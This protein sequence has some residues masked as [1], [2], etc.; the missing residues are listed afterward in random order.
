MLPK[1]FTKD[2]VRR[3]LKHF[4]N[5]HWGDYVYFLFHTGARPSEAIGLRWGDV[6]LKAGTARI[7]ST[8]R[9]SRGS[10]SKRERS[11]TKTGESRLIPLSTVLVSRLYLK[12]GEEHELIFTSPKGHPIDDRNFRRRYWKPALTKLGIEYRRPY[13]MRS[14]CESHLLAS[15]MSV[16]DV[17]AIAG[18]R[19]ET[20]MRHYAGIVRAVKLP[21]EMY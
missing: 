20:L 7:E 19:P 11:S 3:I 8:L 4:D 21:E 14:T 15:G 12:A 6:D 18:H 9:R 16:V 13:L 10:S 5:T 2:E 1:P 17:A